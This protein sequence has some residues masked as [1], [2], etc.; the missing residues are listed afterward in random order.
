MKIILYVHPSADMYGSDKVLLSLVQGLDKKQFHPIVILPS[1]GPLAQALKLLGIEIYILPLSIIGRLTLNPIGLLKLSF[2]LFRSIRAMNKVLANTKVDIVHS[3]TLAVLSG[4][5]WA[6]WKRIP[7]VWHVHEM[8]VHPKFVR[9]SFP[10]LL[11]M[12]AT[13]VVCNSTAT[14]KLLLESQPGLAVKSVVTWNGLKR[15]EKVDKQAVDKLRRQ[16]GLVNNDV[17]IALVGRI[18]RWKGQGLLVEAADLLWK[19]GLRNIHYLIVGS[20]PYRQEC[21]MDSLFLQIAASQAKEQI[22]V[23]NFR[24]DILNVWDACDI[25][26]VPS[27]EPEPFGMVAIEAMASGKPVVASDHGGISEIILHQ[28]TGLLFEPGNLYAFSDALMQLISDRKLRESM[29]HAGMIRVLRE[30]SLEKYI[31]SFE[32]LYKNLL[33]LRYKV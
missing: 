15:T 5:L 2:K 30:F 21:F 9:H 16:L 10:Y 22:T 7:H 27:T 32:S 1:E 33:I 11:R 26:V 23:M 4:A 8:I 13:K 29:G 14:L 3:N 6:K 17:L 31:V 25:A 12:F 19:K 18:N 20:S 24:N 28:K